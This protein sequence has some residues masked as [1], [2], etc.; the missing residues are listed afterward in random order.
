MEEL[1]WDKA[2]ITAINVLILSGLPIM[3]GWH[4]RQ[5]KRQSHHSYEWQIQIFTI[6]LYMLAISCEI[7]ALWAR[8]IAYYQY[9]MYIPSV[10]LKLSAWDRWGRL[11]FYA[12][13]FFYTYTIA[14]KKMPQ[15]VSDTLV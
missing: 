4:V 11:L 3:L 1:N 14:R 2:V 7:P 8:A 12:V 10:L 13:F 6:F 5:A 9:H 15:I